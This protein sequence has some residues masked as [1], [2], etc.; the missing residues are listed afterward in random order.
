V[1]VD[2]GEAERKI[3]MDYGDQLVSEGRNN[4]NFKADYS[5][6]MPCPN[7]WPLGDKEDWADP[8]KYEYKRS[9]KFP[10]C[11]SGENG[12]VDMNVSERGIWTTIECPICGYSTF[13]AVGDGDDLF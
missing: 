12:M 13:W 2:R 10:E 4:V 6:K 1:A 11:P 5:R 9:L 3:H 8:K 7:R